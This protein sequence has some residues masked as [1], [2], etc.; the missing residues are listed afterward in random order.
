MTRPQLRRL[1]TVLGAVVLLSCLTTNASAAKRYQADRF[2]VRISLEAD[3]S[4]RVT[5]SVVFRFEGGT[6]TRVTR[7]LPLRRTD[8]IRVVQATMDRAEVAIGRR[9]ERRLETSR[10]DGRLRAIWRFPATEGAH[11]FSLTYVVAGLVR[12]G[13]VEDVLEWTALPSDHDYQI[14]SS[15]VTLEWPERAEVRSLSAGGRTIERGE[16]R[17]SIGLGGLGKDETLTLRAVFAPGTAAAGPAGWQIREVLG[18]K[19][20]PVYTSIAG[21]L[22][23]AIVVL[24]WFAWVRSS[25]PSGVAREAAG[26]VRVPPADLPPATAG[27]LSER[28][29]SPTGAH[30]M[31]GLLELARRGLI[32]IEARPPARR[33][34]GTFVARREHSAAFRQA[35]RPHEQAL[36]DAA[37]TTKG[38]VEDE[39]ALSTVLGRLAGASAAVREA[40]HAELL[41]AGLLDRDRLRSRRRTLAAALAALLAGIVAVLA[42]IPFA[43]QYG[44]WPLLPGIATCASSLVGFVF[45]ASLRVQTDEGIRQGERWRAYAAFLRGAARN[46]AS[47]PLSL[48]ALPYATAFGAA[49]AFVKRM[50]RGGLPTPAWF[51]AGALTSDQQHAAFVALMSSG[52]V[53]GHAGGGA[54]GAAGAAGGGSSSAS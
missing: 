3:G 16:R 37:F 22:F 29:G 15:Q 31:G 24:F 39:V 9:G 10:G 46:D 14:A 20:A 41:D 25:R 45:A 2:D 21:G 18:R 48:D 43:N 5:E 19:V 47:G 23:A 26:T 38:R 13:A 34:A 11:E 6:Y 36:I 44:A 28:G 49:A 8:G 42:A 53:T 17:A 27:A 52:A 7:E 4:V 30:L 1:W 35:L 50:K 51:D 40:I 54:G 33:G 12:A 32:R